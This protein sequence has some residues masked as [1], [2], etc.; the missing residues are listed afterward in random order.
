MSDDEDIG[1]PAKKKRRGGLREIMSDVLG[2]LPEFEGGDDVELDDLI[3][4]AFAS[5]GDDDNEKGAVDV[6]EMGAAIND[7]L[8]FEEED[9]NTVLVPV[10]ERVVS[11]TAPSLAA[12]RERNAAV[13]DI[14]DRLQNRRQEMTDVGFT[15]QVPLDVISRN[16]SRRTLCSLILLW[17]SWRTAIEREHTRPF[18]ITSTT[19]QR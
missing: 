1:K 14:V 12:I 19:A 18:A 4:E 8:E 9:D 17:L 13:R 6:D 2:D 16:Q 5:D 3:D 11:T 15:L 10:S 7:A